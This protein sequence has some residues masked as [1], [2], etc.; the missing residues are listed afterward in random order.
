MKSGGDRLN[1]SGSA[2]EAVEVARIGFHANLP[3]RLL[4][5]LGWASGVDLGMILREP[6]DHLPAGLELLS[7][8]LFG[9]LQEDLAGISVAQW[10]L[11]AFDHV[12]QQTPFGDIGKTLNTVQ[13]RARGKLLLCRQGVA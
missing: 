11:E 4:Q 1:P 10:V 12:C 2:N 8:E 9:L 3:L 7:R 13:D 5:P 6:V